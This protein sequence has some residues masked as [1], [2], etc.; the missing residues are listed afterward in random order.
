MSFG[1]FP[2][3]HRITLR[4]ITKKFHSIRNKV[5]LCAYSVMSDSLPDPMDY[6]LPG[7]SVHGILQARRLEWVSISSSRGSPQLRDRTHIS[8]ISCTGRRTLL[9]ASGKK[10]VSY[11]GPGV[12][13]TTRFS[14]TPETRRHLRAMPSKF[15][16]KTISNLDF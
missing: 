1:G 2:A 10:K 8:Y 16:G 12:R 11:K 7:A 9:K 5:T 4:L 14:T 6:S 13:M 15:R 3:P